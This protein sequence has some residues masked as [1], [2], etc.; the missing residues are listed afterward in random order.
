[1]RFDGALRYIRECQR[2]RGR[3]RDINSEISTKNKKHCDLV[4][5]C[6]SARGKAV[7]VL[8]LFI[9]FFSDNAKNVMRAMRVRMA[10]DFIFLYRLILF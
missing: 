5:V 6:V 9:C 3:E 7:A 2:A 4:T 8:T 10:I 1:M